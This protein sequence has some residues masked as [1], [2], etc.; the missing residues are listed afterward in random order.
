MRGSLA[1]HLEAFI[2][3]VN[4]AIADAKEQGIV[5]TPDMAR[6]RLNGLA[7][8]VSNVP[9]ITFYEERK[10]A[11]VDGSITTR[12]YSPDPATE[13][14]VMIF[15]H[16]G[17]HMCGSA[18]LYDPM[19]RKIS[20]AGNCIVINVDYR[21]APEFPYPAGLDDA[22]NVVRH[23]RE[24]LTDIAHSQTLI[25]CGDSAG[26]ALCTS[27]SMM[28]AE[29]R[30]LGIDQ[31]V[32]IY[33]SVDYTM[34]HASM[35]ENGTGYFLEKARIQW[36]FDHYFKSTDD[37]RLASPLYGEMNDATPDTM[38]IIA[39]CDPLRDEGL[40]YGDRLIK[41]GVNV[42]IHTFEGMIHAF[43]NIEDLVPEECEQLYRHIGDFV[44]SNR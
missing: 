38:I 31:Q 13:L 11:S 25:I 32:L 22:E 34:S 7:Q 2:E 17:G 19:C 24:L 18:E 4:I 40:A 15:F 20:L 44:R 42:K 9:D 10:L 27:L 8:F 1:P 36:Y 3:Q 14:P 37:R 12:I 43:M 41:A 5:P 16:G 35:D 28:Q 6:E 21:L 30:T 26:G 33:P 23:Y 29:D 39:G